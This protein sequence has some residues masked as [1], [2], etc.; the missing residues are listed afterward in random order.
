MK[1]IIIGVF[2]DFLSTQ[3]KK[4]SLIKKYK[5]ITRAKPSGNQN[6]VRI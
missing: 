2:T 3:L 5:K 1:D 4:E 6:V